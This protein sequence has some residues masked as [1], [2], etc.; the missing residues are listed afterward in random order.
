MVATDWCDCFCRFRTSDG[1]VRQEQGQLKNAGTEN[2]A[3]EVRGSFTYKDDLG[4][5][6]TINF[7]ADENGYQPQVAA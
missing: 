7:L 2:E 5:E 6:H 3:I 4:A 1:I